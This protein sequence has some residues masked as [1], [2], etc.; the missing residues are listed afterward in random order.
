MKSIYIVNHQKA[1]N[2]EVVTLERNRM[3]FP[4][5]G[6]SQ[7]REPPKNPRKHLLRGN[8]LRTSTRH[9]EPEVSLGEC[10]TREIDSSVPFTLLVLSHFNLG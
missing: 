4:T 1:G 9:R 6:C 5:D 3:H 10:Q 7:I 2:K 8:Q